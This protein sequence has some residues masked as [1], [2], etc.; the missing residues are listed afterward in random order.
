MVL[1]LFQKDKRKSYTNMTVKSLKEYSPEIYKTT[2][3][4]QYISIKVTR[5]LIF[6]ELSVFAN[7]FPGS[8]RTPISVPAPIVAYL[9]TLFSIINCIKLVIKRGIIFNFF[10]IFYDK[11]VRKKPKNLGFL[12]I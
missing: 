1:T 3:L 9:Y 12:S 11:C 2:K 4:N 10:K 7:Y 8:G 5:K 6:K